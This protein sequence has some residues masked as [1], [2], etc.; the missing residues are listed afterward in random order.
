[1]QQHDSCHPCGARGRSWRNR[2]AKRCY[3]RWN[4]AIEFRVV[5]D[6]VANSSE[7]ST[8]RLFVVSGVVSATLGLAL[9]A[10]YA[11]YQSEIALAQ[12]AD[13]LA[14]TLTAGALLWTLRLSQKPADAGHPFGHH[15]AQPI[16]ALVVAVFAC[17]L[18]VE[19]AR[20]ALGVL[21]GDSAVRLEWGVVGFLLAKVVVKSALAGAAVRGGPIPSGSALKAFYVDARNDVAVGGASIAGFVAAKWFDMPTLDAWMAL[22]VAAWVAY[23]GADLAFESA[24]VLMG[25]AAPESRMN[26]LADIAANVP[27]VERVEQIKA[28]SVGEHLHVW[29]EVHVDAQLT[30]RRAHDIG[31]AVEQTLLGES[32]VCDAVVHVDASPD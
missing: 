21:L 8:S 25:A 10:A 27:G 32:D 30:V 9:S 20:S 31:E 28:R 1:M 5:S 24:A 3:A 12:A 26:N 14:D 16:A 19:V 18:G 17:V 23:S 22:P 13:S 11:L 29:L 15:S 7:R 4:W 6:A 2:R